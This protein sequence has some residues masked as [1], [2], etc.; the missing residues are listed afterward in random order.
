MDKKIVLDTKPS[1]VT[2]HQKHVIASI[3]KI[4]VM[5]SQFVYK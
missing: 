1:T 4:V 5:F 3:E 2:L